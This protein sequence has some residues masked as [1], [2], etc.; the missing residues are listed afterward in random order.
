MTTKKKH[1]RFSEKEVEKH[2]KNLSSW[3]VNPKSTTLSK[4]FPMANFVGGL[5]FIAK[6]TVHAE[7][8]EH[9]PDIELSYDEVKVKLT[10]HDAEGLTRKDFELA[11]RI[12]GFKMV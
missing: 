6:I 11:E 2:L 1:A 5:A 12:D 4:S 7:V 9:H 3:K 8:L 10:T